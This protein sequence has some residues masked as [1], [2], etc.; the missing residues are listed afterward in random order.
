MSE[1]SKD[2]VK[3]LEKLFINTLDQVKSSDSCNSFPSYSIEDYLGS[4]VLTKDRT[5]PE[6]TFFKTMA[7][8]FSVI[9]PD[10]ETPWK[11]FP[12]Y[13]VSIFNPLSLPIFEMF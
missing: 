9:M 2:A 10:I 6:T 4:L 3:F 7:C 13:E 5:D 11:S 1:L 8:V 12:I